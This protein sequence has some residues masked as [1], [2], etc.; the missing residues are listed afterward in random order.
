LDSNTQAELIADYKLAHTKREDI[1]KEK[2]KVSLNRVKSQHQRFL[3]RGA[4]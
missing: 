3:R 2:K 4:E 1:Q